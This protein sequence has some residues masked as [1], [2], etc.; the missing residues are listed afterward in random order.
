MIEPT[1]PLFPPPR[2]EREIPLKPEDRVAI[3]EAMA[4]LLLQLLDDVEAP[5][6]VGKEVQDER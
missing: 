5:R 3:V 4:A 6:R 2:G 1:L